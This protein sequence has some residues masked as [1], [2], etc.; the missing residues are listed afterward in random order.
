MDSDTIIAALKA[1]GFRHVRTVGSHWQF[2]HPD[3]AGVVTVP[4][5]RKDIVIGTLKSI[6]KQS[7]LTLKRSGS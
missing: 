5:P 1:A 3:R 6:E 4:H 7:G 2:R